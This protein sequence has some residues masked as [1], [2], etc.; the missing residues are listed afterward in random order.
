MIKSI[1]ISIVFFLILIENTY[2][3]AN[4]FLAGTGSVSCPE[5]DVAYGVNAMTSCLTGATFNWTIVG[6]SSY[7]T[8]T[9]GR[10][11]NI[12]WANNNSTKK[13]T[14]DFNGPCGF[15]TFSMDVTLT[16]VIPLPIP[17]PTILTPT[18]TKLCA[19]ASVPLEATM[20]FDPN[21]D[22]N[23]LND[24]RYVWKYSKDG[25]SPVGMPTTATNT[26]NFTLPAFSTGGSLVFYVHT[27]NN[28][29]PNYLTSDI[30]SAPQTVLTPAPSAPDLRAC[31][32][33]TT[34]TLSLISVPGGG[35]GEQYF[36]NVQD[37]GGFGPFQAGDVIGQ[38]SSYAAK[39][40]QFYRYANRPG[41]GDEGCQVS[42][43]TPASN[44]YALTAGGSPNCASGLEASVSG[45]TS[46]YSYSVNNGTSYQAGTTFN[47]LTP[48]SFTVKTKDKY[49]CVGLSSSVTVFAQV[50]HTLS[51]KLACPSVNDG[52]ITINVTGGQ[53]PFE[54]SINGGT[55]VSTTNVFNSL[56]ANTYS[57]YAKDNGGAGC[58]T[59]QSFPLG[60]SPAI[61]IASVIPTAPLCEGGT[62]G[63]LD[64]SASGGTGVFQYSIGSGYQN[65]TTFTGLA[66]NSYIVTVKDG[67]NC[68]KVSGSVPVTDPPAII[69]TTLNVVPRSCEEKTDGIVNVKASG[70]TGARTYSLDDVDYFPEGSPTVFA[71]LPSDAYTVYVKDA[72]GCTKSTGTP[73]VGVLPAIDGTISEEAPISCFGEDDGI[74]KTTPTGGTGPYTILWSN[75][76]TDGLN[77]GLGPDDYS[78]DIL[79]AKGCTKTFSK[80]L[81]EPASLEADPDISSYSGY[82]VRCANGSD[83]SID[84][85]ISGGT[86]PFI[87]T[88]SNGEHTRDINGLQPG[89]YNVTVA[90]AH[91]CN[92]AL[93]GLTISEPVTVGIS[94]VREKNISCN[95]GVDGEIEIGASGG[96]GF[97]E[98]SL[99][100]IDWD[101][102]LFTGLSAG[103]YTLYTRDANLCSRTMTTKLTEPSLLGL[104]I[105]GQIDTS[106]GESN[107]SA[108]VT[109]SGGILSYRYEWRD[110]VNA[111]ISGI[112]QAVSLRSGDYR[113]YVY[114]G[115]NC[116]ADILVT[117]NDSDGPKIQQQS[118]TGLTCNQSNDGAISV[119]ITEGQAPYTITW[120]TQV[121]G[122]T[123][124]SN[125][126]GGEHWVE[127]IDASSC[128]TKRF[129]QVDFPPA[130]ELTIN[131][132][133][134]SCKGNSDGHIEI[135][136]TGGNPGGYEYA[137]TSGQNGT[138]V[139]GIPAGTYSVTVKDSK[140]C[141]LQ[142][143]I[144]LTE[145][146]LFVIDAGGDR[147]ICVGQILKIKAPED[148]ATYEWTS[149][150]GFNSTAR[151][152]SLSIPAK[153]T[154]KIV[155]AD[156]CIAE[157]SF[158]L[159]TSND[160]LRAD[161]LSAH[162]AYA[163]D[164]VV[165]IDISWPVPERIS[166]NF[167]VGSTIVSQQDAYAEVV[168]DN[169]G[170]Y[171]ITL[172]TFLG[173]CI[174]A[175]GKS[176][177]VL[178]E[179]PD[180]GGR[181]G[182]KVIDSFDVHPNPNDGRFTVSITLGEVLPARLM[183]V[184]VSGNK[185]F[186]VSFD[187]KSE[188]I[189]NAVVNNAP[190]GVY[191]L[192]LE[193]GHEKQIKRLIIR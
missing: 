66:A 35:A 14:V 143:N 139:T 69:F 6:A 15:Q 50:G 182:R 122:V 159:Q 175:Y 153:Y 142:K 94:K 100:G 155:N 88:W 149:D 108:T 103:D 64:V 147:T 169:S 5:V 84:L 43:T 131:A 70:G 78:V 162:E 156:G 189:Y 87:Y 30:Q 161:F 171:T 163:G 138:S 40:Y 137:W 19:G 74:L 93:T 91:G 46:P 32:D 17:G 10:G 72:N 4:G 187:E 56:V 140:L 79:D 125:V 81:I 148:N 133:D 28:T 45:G 115:N 104:T 54:Y 33:G 8:N 130:L 98:Y 62:T 170:V 102:S 164:T 158:M 174:D 95:N 22:A 106:C 89:N 165:L 3:Q 13:V 151:E 97:Y 160:L 36:V 16:N 168:F 21:A 176:I 37:A 136:V 41:G 83:G 154:L 55:D 126:T 71:A 112:N 20:S 38:V 57:V 24:V 90:D 48:G 92:V 185:S 2:S 110:A 167:P 124:I 42:G 63:S 47:S 180:T 190:A 134:P 1:S 114:D 186:T 31:V 107:G 73:F 128:R 173:E 123:A 177:T 80:T 113:A 12:K 51:T 118:L 65:E 67:N 44:A 75:G 18:T 49:G 61:N 59:T 25:A 150:A 135:I 26:T 141:T 144:L 116:P 117:I 34:G 193:A 58:T 86:G 60:N 99:D 191:F 68:T 184:N 27:Y 7:A 9:G 181:K 192:I 96:V 152:V 39:T 178:G 82:G 172:N 146:P 85:D 109:A 120:D 52:R 105:A 101:A 119:A 145:P 53:G 179:R 23:A 76:E 166:W 29:C 183:M 11:V 121:Q 127:V 157:D 188:I 77:P 132:S 111:L 129:F